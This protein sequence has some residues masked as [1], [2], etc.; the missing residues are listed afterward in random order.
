M[1]S[2]K[3]YGDPE[4][5]RRI[6]EITREL[7]VERGPGLRL[8]DLAERAGVSR[9]ALYLHFGDRRGLILALV[10]HM[11][12]TLELS[13]QLANVYGAADGAE[14]LE[15]MMRLNTEFWAAVAPV[16]EVLIASRDEALSSAWRDRMS[17]RRGTFRR[18]VEVIS[19]HGELAEVWSIDAAAALMFAAAHF[20][21]WRELTVE[22]GWS[23]DRYVEMM[24]LMLQRALLVGS[25]A[26]RPSSSLDQ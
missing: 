23:D 19:E 9:Q 1:T 2:S 16:A 4:T 24:T 6:L 8:K 15:R 10:R 13:E 14:L 26:G 3:N 18:A 5:R 20:D 22:L 12:A 11:D 17:Y 25:A 7:L 21:A